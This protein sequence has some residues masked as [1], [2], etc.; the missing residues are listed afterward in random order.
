[1][2]EEPTA[3][4]ETPKQEAIQDSTIIANVIELAHKAGYIAGRE[5]T[6]D[7]ISTYG[8]LVGRSPATIQRYFHVRELDSLTAFAQ[9][10]KGNQ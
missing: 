3:E 7:Y 1:M 2:D 6:N 8:A 4:K 5:A 10:L 9:R